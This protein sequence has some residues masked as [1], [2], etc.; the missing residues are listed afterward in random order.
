VLAGGLLVGALW[1][2]SLVRSGAFADFWHNYLTFAGD[3]LA[4]S[5]PLKLRL[6][7]LVGKLQPWGALHLLAVPL[8]AMAIL[9]AAAAR[10]GAAPPL[11]AP[12][13]LG[14]LYLG[15]TVQA[16]FMQFEFDYQIAPCVFLAL[17]QVAC[18]LAGRPGRRWAWAAFVAFGL[19]AILWQPALRPGRLALWARCWREGSTDELRDRLTMYDAG[20]ATGWRDLAA[21]EDFL[22]ERR[23]GDDDVLSYHTSTLPVYLRLGVRPASRYLYPSAYVFNFERHRDA[24][25]QELRAGPQR[26]IVTDLRALWGGPDESVPPESETDPAKLIPPHLAGAYPY[27]ERP[28]H[29]FGRYLVHEVRRDAAP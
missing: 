5:P 3:Y 25:R 14:G 16:A 15:W 6:V 29:R 24:I 1:Q 11:V 10:P 26:F 13:L 22:R 21:V 28:V 23:A 18:W 2:L 7:Y 20:F 8:A 17:A 4:M 9:R 27:S 12:A 19:V